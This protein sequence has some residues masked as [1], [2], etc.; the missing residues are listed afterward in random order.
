[1]RSI[2]VPHIPYIA[3]K[4]ALDLLNSGFVTFSGGIESIAKVA[5]EIIRADINRERAL[6]EKASELMDNNIDDIESMQV[7]KRNMFWMIKRKLAD[8]IG[9]S[10]NY[11]DRYSEISHNILESSWKKGYIDYK[12]SENRVKNIIYMAIEEYLKNYEKV[13]DEVADQIANYKRKLIPGTDEYDLVFEELYEKE[14][15]KRGVIR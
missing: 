4:I 11:E 13:E 3:Q 1:M 8:E 9:F 14:L 5:D 6:D 7:D 2:R 12:V 15:R 10:L